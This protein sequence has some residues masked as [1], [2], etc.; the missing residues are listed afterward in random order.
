MGELYAHDGRVDFESL[1]TLHELLAECYR[2][3]EEALAVDHRAADSVGVALQGTGPRFAALADAHE[4]AADA[5]RSEEAAEAEEAAVGREGAAADGGKTAEAIWLDLFG[6]MEG[7][8]EQDPRL[9]ARRGCLATIA[10]GIM[11]R[12]LEALE[13]RSRTRRAGVRRVWETA[14]RIDER[15]DAVDTWRCFVA[16]RVRDVGE[17]MDGLGRG[18]RTEGRGCC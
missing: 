5:L 10:D 12:R 3:P 18:A 7:F 4:R 6:R 9:S 15:L 13:R 8:E 2:L 1:S 14:V 11:R 16:E 17:K